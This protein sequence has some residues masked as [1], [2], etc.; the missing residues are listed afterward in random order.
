MHASITNFFLVIIF[1]LGFFL[2]LT[3]SWYMIWKY[4]LSHI[5]IVREVC[6]LDLYNKQP[7]FKIIEHENESKIQVK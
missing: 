6:G 4:N 3:I 7:S 5:P 2:I 1:Y